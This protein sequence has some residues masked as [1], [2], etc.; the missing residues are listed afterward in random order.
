[1]GACGGLYRLWHVLH[2]YEQGRITGQ[3][4]QCELSARLFRAVAVFSPSQALLDNKDV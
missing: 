2:A 3:T 4:V 1:L